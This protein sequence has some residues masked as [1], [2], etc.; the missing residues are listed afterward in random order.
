MNI[1]ITEMLY[2]LCDVLDNKEFSN[3][4]IYFEERKV[5]ECHRLPVTSVQL[6]SFHF[7]GIL[8]NKL[9]LQEKLYTVFDLSVLF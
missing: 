5:L 2:R 4:E 1:G 9:Y 3:F 7:Q 8:E 6:Q